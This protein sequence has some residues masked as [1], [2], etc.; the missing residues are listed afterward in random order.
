MVAPATIIA[1]YTMLQ[2]I[3]SKAGTFVVRLL[4]VLLI[5]SFGVWGIGD[6]LRQSPAD[7]TVIVV[8]GEKIA[9]DRVQAELRRNMER[10]RQMFGGTLD[11]EQARAMGLVD[12][13]VEGIVTE[14]LLDQEA[15]RLH[16]VIGDQQVLATITQEPMFKGLGGVFDRTTFMNILAANRMSEASYLA[17]VRTDMRRNIIA[18]AAGATSDTPKIL[19]DTLYKIRDEKRVANWVFLPESGV[20]DIPAADDAALQA[21]YDKNNDSFS[22]PEYRGFTA[23]VMQ[24]ADVAADVQITDDQI[25]DAYQQRLGD[26]TKPE[27]RHVLQIVLPDEKTAGEAETALANGQTLEDVA[28]NIAKQD[29][30]TIDLGTLTKTELPQEIGDAAFAA[31]QD[32]IT[33]PVK[34]ALGWHILK[35][36]GIEPGGVKSLDEVKK[37]IEADLRKEAEGDAL[38]KLT[39][40][41]EDAIAAGAELGAIAQQ[42]NLKP[43]TIAAVDEGGK[44][45]DGK[46][47]AGLPIPAAPILKTVF[48]T[49]AGQVSGVEEAAESAAFYVVKVDTDTPAA[50]R[51]FDQVKDQVKAA[52]MKEQQAIKVAEQAKAMVDGVKIDVPLAKLAA[53]RKL[54]VKTTKPFERTNS[55]NDVPLPPQLITSLFTMQPGGTANAAGNQGQYVAEL[56]EIQPADPAADTNGVGQLAKQ[57]DQEIKTEMLKELDTALRQRYPVEIRQAALD[58]VVGTGSAP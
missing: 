7:A 25:K 45:P 10:A 1:W 47:I 51:P 20:T 52:W 35:I 54:A 3:R 4:F 31:T 56:K 13:T 16:I 58:R 8:G 15:K 14:A 55:K 38:Y 42:F 6:F 21:Y 36:T 43:I 12:R 41:V 24:G 30:T 50:L 18:S 40:K 19:T 37:T 9:G 49:A 2:F 26:F 27:K 11:M 29:A 5:A 46:I 32:E 44:D 48:E 34:S 39:N 33:Q 57:L 17:L 53:E 28:K 22:A 23:L